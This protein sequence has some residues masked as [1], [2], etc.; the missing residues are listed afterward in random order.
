MLRLNIISVRRIFQLEIRDPIHGSIELTPTET[1]VIDSPYFQRLRNI[2]QMG[3]AE[4]SFPGATHN[5]YCHSLG[6]MHLAG[7]AFDHIFQGYGFSSK[8]V[9]WRLRQTIRL[10]SLLHDVGH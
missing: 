8:E 5:R 7:L 2:K 9:K 6:A 1:A 10:A 3:F 4:F